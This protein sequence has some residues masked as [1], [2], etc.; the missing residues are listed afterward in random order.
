MTTREQATAIALALPGTEQKRHFG[1]VDFRVRTKV[2]AS[3][4]NPD[5]ITLRLDPDHARILIESNP[6]TYIPHSG[7]WG[8]RGW[9]RLVLSRIDHD[10][11]AD[12]VYDSW[13][14]IAPKE[15][16]SD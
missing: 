10:V 4:P 7:V 5:Q 9:I 3:F 2:F 12:L 1:N 13:S 8:Q 16:K 11:L 6:E 15:Y 14:R